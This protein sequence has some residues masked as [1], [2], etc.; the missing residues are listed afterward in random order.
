MRFT[1]PTRNLRFL[2]LGVLAIGILASMTMLA[3]P[4]TSQAQEDNPDEVKTPVAKE[5]RNPIIH[6]ATD[7][8]RSS[9]VVFGVALPFVV[10]GM[11][12]LMIAKKL[13]LRNACFVI[14]GILIAGPVWGSL[15]SVVGTIGAFRVLAE[16][17]GA[18]DAKALADAPSLAFA[19][20]CVGLAMCPVGITTIV[21]AAF[22]LKSP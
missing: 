1:C 18:P 19:S 5:R 11:V 14:G 15:G 2:A 17:E 12:L 20:I 9:C 8:A 3:T 13:T 10:F 7:C 16:T 6:L 22:R 21:F 4:D